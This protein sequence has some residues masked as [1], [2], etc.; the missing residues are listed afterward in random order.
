MNSKDEN[1]I[2]TK[3]FT[4]NEVSLHNKEDDCWIILG[5]EVYDVTPFLNEH[6]GGS[7]IL[8]M[9]GGKNCIEE[10]QDIGHG[11]DAYKLLKMYKIG[12]IKKEKKL[13]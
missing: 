8:L 11:E 12:H 10:F 7:N 9:Y 13:N 1:N 4:E 6:P 3:Y 2:K 5:D